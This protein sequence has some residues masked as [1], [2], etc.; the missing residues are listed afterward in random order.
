MSGSDLSKQQSS[1]GNR[2]IELQHLSRV[3]GMGEIASGLAH[4]LTQPLTAILNYS[5][6]CIL[7]LEQRRDIP[8][9]VLE[10]IRE[11]VNETR[12]AGV[13]CSRMRLLNR[14]CQPVCVRVDVNELVAEAVRIMDRDF[15]HRGVRVDVQLAD[16]LPNAFGDPIHILYVLTE[17]MQNACAAMEH[18]PADGGVLTVATSSL[19]D[20]KHVQVSVTDTGRGMS[21]G[22]LDRLFEP[23]F[24][25][26]PNGVGMGLITCRA[27]V[28]NMGGQLVGRA[29]VDCGM[30]FT[31]TIPVARNVGL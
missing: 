21:S 9:S 19:A 18:T 24:S 31:F 15:H 1:G 3:A 14:K 29:G 11:V 17:L 6:V 28:E 4:E 16:G 20:G 23:F 10:L 27:M 8:E 5:G 12:R 25:T 26:K 13:I 22:E 2:E 7:Q 30:A